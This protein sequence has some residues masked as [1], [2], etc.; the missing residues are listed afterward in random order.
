MADIN[1]L[2]GDITHGKWDYGYKEMRKMGLLN[3]KTISLGSNVEKVE[4][5]TEESVKKLS[6]TAGWGIL[7]AAVLG[8]IGAI[9]GIIFGCRKKDICFACYLKN[10]KKFM[11]VSKA[12]IYQKIVADS[13]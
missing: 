3:A 12:K 2:A 11:A 13:F 7:G 10:G 4:M 8:P 1:V 9:G 5:L 6:G